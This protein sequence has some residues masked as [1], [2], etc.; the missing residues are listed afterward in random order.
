MDGRLKGLRALEAGRGIRT[1]GH[2]GG[3][4]EELLHRVGYPELEACTTAFEGGTERPRPHL[5]TP[6]SLTQEP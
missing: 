4:G 3:G 6:A 5:L 1:C 2:R